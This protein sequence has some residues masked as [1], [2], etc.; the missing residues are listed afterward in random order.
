MKEIFTI[1]ILI[2]S[3][4]MSIVVVIKILFNSLN[5]KSFDI[6]PQGIIVSI[7]WGIFY[8]LTHY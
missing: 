4:F 2:L 7:C 6:T 1:I 5:N 8:Y 3:I